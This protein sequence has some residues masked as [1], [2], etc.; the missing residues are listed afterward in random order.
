MGLIYVFLTII[1]TVYG[2][3]VI[4]WQMIQAGEFPVGFYSKIIFFF[5]VLINPWVLS[6]FLAAFFAALSWMAAM[7]KLELSYAY[8][9]MSL[10]FVLVLIFSAFFLHE[11]ISYVKILSLVF[12]VFGVALLGWG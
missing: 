5:H 12:I 6:A 8:P 2:Q 3:L 10:S 4:K 1:F 11:P 9:F 7:T